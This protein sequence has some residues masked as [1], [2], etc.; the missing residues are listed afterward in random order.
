L[1]VFFS[2]VESEALSFSKFSLTPLGASAYITRKN[3]IM[4]VIRS[5]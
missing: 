1:V 4:R 2:E 3:T 5:A